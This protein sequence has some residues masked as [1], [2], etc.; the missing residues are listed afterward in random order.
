VIPANA[1]LRALQQIEQSRAAQQGTI[2]ATLETARWVNIGPA[3]ILDGPTP[4]SGR[5]ADIAVDPGDRGHWL[6]GAAQG[7]IWETRDAGTTW[8]P[9]TDDQVSL[10]MGAIA[11]APSDPRIVYAGT[12]EAVFSSISTRES[13]F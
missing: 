1:R 6:I 3:P 13:V 2:P 10:A 5:V 8:T 11:F 4:M 7:G 9:R 12:G